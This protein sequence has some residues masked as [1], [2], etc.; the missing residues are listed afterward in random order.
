MIGRVCSLIVVPG[1]ALLVP[2]LGL[3]DGV[4]TSQRAGV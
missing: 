1:G 4:S 2:V 3:L